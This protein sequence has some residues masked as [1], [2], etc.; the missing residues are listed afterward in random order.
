VSELLIII[1]TSFRHDFVF[2]THSASVTAINVDAIMLSRRLITLLPS[3][4]I[5]AITNCMPAVSQ[6][7]LVGFATL[8]AYCFRFPLNQNARLVQSLHSLCLYSGCSGLS[9]TSAEPDPGWP[10]KTVST[11]FEVVFGWS[12]ADAVVYDV[13]ITQGAYNS[14]KPGKHGNLREFVNSGKLRE[15]SGNLKFTQG[16]YMILSLGHRVMCII[17][18]NSSVNWLGDTVSGMGGASH[19]AHSIKYSVILQESCRTDC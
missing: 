18:S 12:V 7:L 4:H 6:G 16:I 19:H 11:A 5:K 1:L 14:G 3:S 9:C 10:R 8:C 2:A 17:V 13:I 15:N